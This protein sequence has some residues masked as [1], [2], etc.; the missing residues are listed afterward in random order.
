MSNVRNVNIS[1]AT[2][3][4][5]FDTDDIVQV[6]ITRGITDGS[7]G[8]G[9]AQSDMIRFTAVSSAKLAKKTRCSVTITPGGRFGNY[10]VEECVRDGSLI[11]VTAFDAMYYQGNAHVKFGG[12]SSIHLEKLTFPCMMQDVLDYICTLRNMSCSFQCQPFTVPKKPK[13]PDGTY[14]TVR[15]LIGFIAASHGCNAKFDNQ[16]HLVFQ[17]FTESSEGITASDAV[18]FTLD[19]GEPF[20]VTGLLFHVDSETDVYIDDVPGSEY[21]EDDDGV[22][23]CYNPLATVE[24][25]NYAWTQIGGLAYY[26]GSIT[27]R[28][29][30]AINCGDVL[31]VQNLKYPAD[32]EDYLLCV[33]DISY[34]ISADTGFMMTLTSTAG[35]TDNGTPPSGTS[36]TESYGQATD[37]AQDT[38]T[39]IKLSDL[40]FRTDSNGKL[41]SVS[42]RVQNDNTNAMEWD[43]VCSVGSGGVGENVGQ[44][45]ERFN[46]YT[47]AD[48]CTITSGDYNHAE[49]YKNTLTNAQKTHI[50]GS[51]N[52]ITNVDSALISGNKN[53]MTNSGSTGFVLTGDE[54]EIRGSIQCSFVGGS[55]NKV[56]SGAINS[57]IVGASNRIV[58]SITN[59]SIIAGYSNTI[60]GGACQLI[61]GSGNTVSAGWCGC[62]GDENIVDKGGCWAVGFGADTTNL[63]NSTRFVIGSHGYGA[64]TGNAMYATSLGDIYIAGNYNTMGADY[65]EYFEWADGNPENEDRRGMLVALDGDKIVPA[66]GYDIFGAVSANPSVVGNSAVLNWEGKYKRDV[67]GCTVRNKDGEPILN[68]DYDPKKKYIPREQRPEWAAVG[69]V[70]RLIVIDNGSCKAGEWVVGNNGY[71]FP[72]LVGKTNVRC[73]KRIDD[74]HVEVF[75]R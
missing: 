5:T 60:V 16:E 41:Q 31:T 7:F 36:K 14:F 54:N 56:Y 61:A 19:D 65:A 71:A 73:L 39:N 18:D 26:S 67:F 20:E 1:I 17:P 47:A 75:I 70:G 9:F 69:L 49:G 33:T 21:D 6:D 68:P 74:M 29:S 10:Y 57:I 27:M 72:S 24:I 4:A 63:P 8:I 46:G 50:G 40:W 52:D 51:E 23:K 35:K 25:A 59:G 15:E 28:G 48:G 13:K 30:G 45:N 62:V 3:S 22:V 2:S 64:G 38:G 58:N 37:P 66:D 12:K 44:H 42:K 55:I 34:S 11:N 53:V 32:T 43:P